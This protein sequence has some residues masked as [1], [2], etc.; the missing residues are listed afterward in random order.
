MVTPYV[1]FHKLT[2][3]ANKYCSHYDSTTENCGPLRLEDNARKRTA[4]KKTAFLH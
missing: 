4:N 3:G 1:Q 2:K